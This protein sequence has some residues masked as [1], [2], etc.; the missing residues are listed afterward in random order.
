[1]EKTESRESD[2]KRLYESGLTVREIAK[3][4]DMTTQG[5]HWHLKRLGLSTPLSR[6]SERRDEAS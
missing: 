3:V 5:V 4:T 2:V 6:S 1:V